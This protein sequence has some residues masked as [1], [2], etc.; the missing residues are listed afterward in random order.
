MPPFVLPG[1][2]YLGPGNK[3]NSG[4]PVNSAD[5]IA[6][7]HDNAYHNANTKQDIYDADKEAINEFASNFIEKPT[8]GAAL[9][10]IGLGAKHIVETSLNTLI[11]PS[12]TG[13]SH[14][15][16]FNSFNKTRIYTEQTMVR[17]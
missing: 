5:F 14:Y 2:K 9:G 17:I 10:Y 12:I 15:E 6:Q 7:K 11:Y 13:N 4:A 1:Y 3:L 16:P 8:I